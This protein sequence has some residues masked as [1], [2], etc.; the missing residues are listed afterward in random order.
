MI[1]KTF[2]LSAIAAVGMAGAQPALAQD[3]TSPVPPIYILGEDDT[4]ELLSCGTSY[5]NVM[6][7][8]Q[9]QFQAAGVRMGTQDQ[10][11]GQQALTFYINLNIS[12]I[13]YDDGSRTGSCY[14]AVNVR[15]SSYDILMEPVS[16]TR[17]FATLNFCA[18]GFTFTLTEDSL[19]SFVNDEVR[20][21]VSF[22]LQEWLN[23]AE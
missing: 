12:P 6:T 1:R 18:D 2:S 19:R 10:S 14:G 22:C 17:R 5:A 21:K 13:V 11:L 9:Q 20:G 16:G 8:A 23:S 15:L 3:K 4:S 7:A